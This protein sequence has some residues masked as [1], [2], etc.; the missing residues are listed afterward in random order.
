MDSETISNTLL[1]VFVNEGSTDGTRVHDSHGAGRYGRR[2][3][4]WSFAF[5]MFFFGFSYLTFL[6]FG[7]RGARGFTFYFSRM[8]FFFW[9]PQLR[10]NWE[11]ELGV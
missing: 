7:G 11:W 2:G 5:Y 6:G 4:F 9:Q 1:N 8:K 3:S 10:A